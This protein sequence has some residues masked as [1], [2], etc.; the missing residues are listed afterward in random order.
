[1][2]K[3]GGRLAETSKE[4]FTLTIKKYF[5]PL[6]ILGIA[7]YAHFAPQ[8]YVF[9]WIPACAV[10]Q[11]ITVYA[12]SAFVFYRHQKS[13]PIDGLV[14]KLTTFALG[15]ETTCRIQV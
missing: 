15:R 13:E 3:F 4:H 2:L 6:L 12:L 9:K 5:E 11:I 7:A 14:N 8:E 1:M 10:G